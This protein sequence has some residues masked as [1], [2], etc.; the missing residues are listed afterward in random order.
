MTPSTLVRSRPR[1]PINFIGMIAAALEKAEQPRH[2]VSGRTL[3]T[4]VAKE[5]DGRVCGLPARYV[6]FNAGGHVCFSHRP[7]RKQEALCLSK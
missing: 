3:P 7:N 4:C 2:H 5:D 1:G 6:D